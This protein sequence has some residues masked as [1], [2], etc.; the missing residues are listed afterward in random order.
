MSDL[1]KDLIEAL[2]AFE[3]WMNRPLARIH[4]YTYRLSNTIHVEGS[5]SFHV[6]P[7]Y[8]SP[9]VREQRLNVARVIKG[10]RAKGT[11]PCLPRYDEK[12]AHY[13]YIEQKGAC[14]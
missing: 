2:G 4:V 5:Y 7:F 8:R 9:L 1:R 13:I 14:V 11:R 12:T 3:R 10:L 6:R